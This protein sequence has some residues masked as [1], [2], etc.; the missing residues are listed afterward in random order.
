MLQKE[1]AAQCDLRGAFLRF[2]ASLLLL[3]DFVG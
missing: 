2:P 1:N 3:A